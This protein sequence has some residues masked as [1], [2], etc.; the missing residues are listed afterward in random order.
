MYKYVY[1]QCTVEWLDSSKMQ[2]VCWQYRCLFTLVL[3]FFN[4]IIYNNLYFFEAQYSFGVLNKW[5]LS[6]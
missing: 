5:Y 6:Q 1:V 2:D 3:C 4:V